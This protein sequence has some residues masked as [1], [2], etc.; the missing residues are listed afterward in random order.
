MINI[1]DLT[2]RSTPYHSI[3]TRVKDCWGDCCAN[4]ARPDDIKRKRCG[5]RMDLVNDDIRKSLIEL[6]DA[7]TVYLNRSI[8]IAT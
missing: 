1:I 7:E 8:K 3:I 6:L 5:H 4:G 2:Y